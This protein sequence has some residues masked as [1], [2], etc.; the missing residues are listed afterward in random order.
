MSLRD[1]D[2]R[3]VDPFPPS[4]VPQTLLDEATSL[5]GAFAQLA[6]TF[7]DWEGMVILD[8]E[9]REARLTMRQLWQRARSVQ[10]WLVSRGFRPGDIA[11]LTLPTGPEIVAAYFGVMLAG[12]APGLVRRPRRGVNEAAG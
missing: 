9:R 12:G 1:K 11:L 4:G 5:T 3:T 2:L 7:P 8:G 10:A 6:E